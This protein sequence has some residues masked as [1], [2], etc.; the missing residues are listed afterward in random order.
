[1]D[2]PVTVHDLAAALPGIGTLRD[3]CRALALLDAVLSPAWESRYH[4]FGAQGAP[5]E[6]V[7]SMDNGSGDAYSIAFT[8]AGVFV[9]GFDHESPMSPAVND[10]E[11][12][13]GLVDTVPA[14][15]AAQVSEPSFGYE[16]H[17]EATVCLWR[18]SG[19]DR[20]HAGDIDFPA[21]DDPDGA[22][23]LFQLVV[24]PSGYAAWARDYFEQDVDA[25]AVAEILAGRPHTVELFRRLNAEMSLADF[26]DLADYADLVEP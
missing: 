16:G 25:A 13:P 4:F 11:L 22:N 24:D 9:R 2:G 5:G 21:G 8:T 10:E 14:V 23:W 19:D 7:A 26:A 3:R 20:W 6:E 12:W 1:L 15:F 18:E 17:L